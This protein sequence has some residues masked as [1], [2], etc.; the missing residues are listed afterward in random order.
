LQQERAVTSTL[1]VG[2][3]PHTPQLSHAIRE[4][5]ETTHCDQ[6]HAYESHKELTTLPKID[7]LNSREISLI[8]LLAHAQGESLK[9][10]TMERDHRLLVFRLV[11]YE[12]H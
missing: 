12:T 5:L 11:S 10:A 4:S 1:K 8:L 7:L 9:H 6:P 3:N 2:D